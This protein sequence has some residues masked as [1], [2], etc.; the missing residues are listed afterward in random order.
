MEL[1]PPS[2]VKCV[3]KYIFFASINQNTFINKLMNNTD[4]RKIIEETKFKINETAYLY[5]KI[6]KA[7]KISNHSKNFFNELVNL[8]GI[9]FYEPESRIIK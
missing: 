9:K 4:Y 1:L 6:V 3:T 8:M 7:K 5:E 2:L